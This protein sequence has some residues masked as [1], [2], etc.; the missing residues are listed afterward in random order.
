[1]KL[2]MVQAFLST[3]EYAK[4]DDRMLE[5][6]QTMRNSFDTDIVAFNAMYP[7][8]D[9]TFSEDWQADIDTAHALPTADEEIA[10]LKAL[11]E[12]IYIQMER[13]RVQYQLMANY[14]RLLFPY[15]KA[16][17]GV[18][19]LHK[20]VRVR[21]TQSELYDLMQQANR[22]CNDAEYNADLIAIGFTQTNIDKL[23]TL[24]NAL[25]KAIKTQ[26]DYKQEIQLNTEARV[27]AYNKV[28]RV[29]QKISAA[30]KQVFT[31]NYA[32]LEQYKL[33][34]EV[35]GGFGKLKNM[36]ADVEPIDPV[37]SIINI[38]TTQDSSGV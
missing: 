18:F 14:I 9:M 12:D 16:M 33:Y 13:C 24:A 32:K 5:Q 30:S 10:E 20:Y 7:M 36:R 23:G 22:K 37:L 11:T 29:T 38:E 1:M 21:R 8:F 25:H 15:S 31:V 2:A 28:W 19:G 27:E 26:K 35:S 6:A 4:P 34:P 17:Q 3:R